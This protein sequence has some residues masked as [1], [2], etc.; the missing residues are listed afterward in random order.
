MA[1]LKK[2]MY[3]TLVKRVSS[4]PRNEQTRVLAKISNLMENF[5]IPEKEAYARVLSGSKK[6]SYN[7]GGVS[8]AKKKQLK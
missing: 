7:K 5:N 6:A 3:D 2:D 8:K 4:M 1:A